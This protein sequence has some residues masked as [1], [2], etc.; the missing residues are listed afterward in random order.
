MLNQRQEGFSW[1]K[2]LIFGINGIKIFLN[3]LDSNNIKIV[4]YIN[5][6][7]E[8]QPMWQGQKWGDSRIQKSKKI[9]TQ[10]LEKIRSFK[11]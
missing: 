2:I 8:S 1:A 5:A 9:K 6:N 4:S 7:W 11:N 10:W 3:L